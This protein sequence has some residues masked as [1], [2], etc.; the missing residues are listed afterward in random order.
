MWQKFLEGR[1]IK[2]YSKKCFHYCDR[3]YCK[4]H[5]SRSLTETRTATLEPNRVSQFFWEIFIP[6]GQ[7]YRL[8]YLIINNF[9]ARHVHIEKFWIALALGRG[10]GSGN[11]NLGWLLRDPRNTLWR[12][13]L[14]KKPLAESLTLYSLSRRL[15]FS[16]KNKRCARA[17]VHNSEAR[18][19]TTSP[20]DPAGLPKG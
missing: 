14:L 5:D 19:L 8:Y 16:S 4:P 6:R 17:R 10:R 7:L 11:V 18:A 20:W 9:L 2:M 15:R 12:E 1:L 13:I 3:N